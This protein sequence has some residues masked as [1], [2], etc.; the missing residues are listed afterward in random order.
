MLSEELRS[1]KIKMRICFVLSHLPQGGAERQTINLIRKLNPQDFEVT[2][3]LYANQEIFYKEILELP[4]QI[5]SCPAYRKSKLIKNVKGAI[6][7]KKILSRYQVD[8]IHTLLF[9]NGLIVRL[10]APGRYRGRIIYSIRNSLEQS[11]FFER[12]VEKFLHSRSVTVTNSRF[13]LDQY[14]NIVR[15]CSSESCL[16]IYNGIETEKFRSEEP[17]SVGDHFVIGT[18]GRQTLMKNHIQ[19]LRVVREL[20]HEIP[21]HLYII[22]DSNQDSFK[23]NSEFINLNG[24]SKL[25]TILDSQEDIEKYY[26]IQY[27]RFNVTFR[28]LSKCLI[29]SNAGEMFMYCFSWI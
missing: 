14:K 28:K 7:L 22:G 9:H 12:S 2:L 17:P 1:K 18:I 10:L 15:D 3:V 20:R 19:L 13:V 8:L 6:F 25:V 23:P 29:G 4:V 26:K 27:I 24:L 16:A 21:F 5:I 11:S